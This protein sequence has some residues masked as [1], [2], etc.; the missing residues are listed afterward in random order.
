RLQERREELEDALR[1]AA[2]DL[3]EWL[4]RRRF[5]R[6]V[7]LP[8]DDVRTEDSGEQVQQLRL[9]EEPQEENPGGEAIAAE[10]LAVEGPENR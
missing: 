2:R 7:A 9:T 4:E 1:C 3:L 5:D 8:A 10:T 6:V